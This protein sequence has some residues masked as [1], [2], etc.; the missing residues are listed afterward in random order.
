MVFCFAIIGELNVYGMVEA[1]VA[2]VEGELLA[3][4]TIMS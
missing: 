4:N 1:Q 2:V 3:G